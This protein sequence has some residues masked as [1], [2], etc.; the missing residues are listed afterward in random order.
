MLFLIYTCFDVGLKYRLYVKQTMIEFGFIQMEVLRK[1]KIK[2]VNASTE[3]YKINLYTSM[4]LRIF[5]RIRYWI[6]SSLLISTIFNNFNLLFGNRFCFYRMSF[7]NLI[8]KN[9]CEFNT[10]IHIHTIILLY[11]YMC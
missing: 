4:I 11:S 6:Y 3:W 10:H 5:I 9:K 1:I 7:F 8:G 2:Y